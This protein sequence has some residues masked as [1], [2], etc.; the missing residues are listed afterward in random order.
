M[1]RQGK[2][3]LVGLIGVVILMV[4]GVLFN[5]PIKDKWPVGRV[6]VDSGTNLVMGTLANIVAV[7]NDSNVG[8]ECIKEGMGQLRLVDELM[9]DYKADSQLSLVNRNAFK[10]AVEVDESVFAVLQRSIYYSRLSDGA[11]DITVGPLV[12]MWR[13]AGRSGKVPTAEELREAESRVGYEKLVLDVENRTVRFA[14]EGMR[15]DL[16]AIAKGYA[17]DKAVEAMEELGAFGGMVDVGGDIRCFG[18]SPPGKQSWRIGLRDAGGQRDSSGGKKLMMIL[19]LTDE[20]VATSGN[21]ERF[22]TVDGQKFNHIID[23]NSGYGSDKLASITIIAKSSMDA[24]ALATI[25]SVMGA[26]KGLALIERTADVE[27]IVV[28]AKPEYKVIKSSGAKKYID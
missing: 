9:S 11:F 5:R 15:L 27:A 4:V 3:I 14:V 19:E 25:V 18:A 28:T 23:V 16:G 21:Y 17:I 8:A 1:D 2:R 26:E 7:A 22:F 12:D 24:D 10:E 6:V 20:A 13:Q